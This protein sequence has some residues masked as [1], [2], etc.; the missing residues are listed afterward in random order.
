MSQTSLHRYPLKRRKTDSFEVADRLSDQPGIGCVPSSPERAQRGDTSV[1][2]NLAHAYDTGQGIRRSKRKA[3]HWY[4]RALAA[5]EGAAAHN[6]A[7][8]YR[9]RADTIRAARRFAR[10]VSLASAAAI[11]SS[12]NFFLQG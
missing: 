2:L 3:L 5:S 4:R 9:D 11:S 10:A 7:T 1:P 6:I 8:V 12:G